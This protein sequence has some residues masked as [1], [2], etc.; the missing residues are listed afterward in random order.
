VSSF[1]LCSG[2]QAFLTG[3]SAGGLAA[4]LHCDDFRTRFPQ[5]VP[6]K[7]L[8]DAGFFIDAYN[9]HPN[10]QIIQLTCICIPMFMYQNLAILQKGYIGA[11]VHVVCI[12]WSCSPSGKYVK[13]KCFLFSNSVILYECS[14]KKVYP[15]VSF[16]VFLQ[17]VSKVLPKDCLANKDPTEVCFWN[18]S[19]SVIAN[20]LNPKWKF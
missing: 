9:F 20:W 5:N 12:Q 17:N 7:C 18:N 13:G 16:Y 11:K 3:G 2:L 1:L 8:S 14:W 15:F 10:V 4:L 19:F 6:V